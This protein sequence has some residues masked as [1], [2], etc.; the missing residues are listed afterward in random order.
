MPYDT[1][2]PDRL[3]PAQWNQA[4]GLARQ[5][6]A[7]IFRDGGNPADA[8]RAFGLAKPALEISDWSKAVERIAHTLCTPALRRAA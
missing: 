3:D 6:C 8:L 7:R 5:A 4:I 2:T 1:A